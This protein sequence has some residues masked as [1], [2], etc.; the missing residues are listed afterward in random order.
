LGTTTAYEIRVFSMISSRPV[1]VRVSP[2][3]HSRLYGFDI[4]PRKGVVVAPYG[5]KSVVI[6][7]SQVVRNSELE[8]IFGEKEVR[9]RP[10]LIVE[11]VVLNKRE[12]EW[13]RAGTLWDQVGIDSVMLRT[14]YWPGD[15]ESSVTESEMAEWDALDDAA[16][17]RGEGEDGVEKSLAAGPSAVFVMA[18]S[19][20]VERNR[21]VRFVD[22]NA[23]FKRDGSREGNGGGPLEEAMPGMRRSKS[24]IIDYSRDAS[25]V[26]RAKTAT[27][28]ADDELYAV[29]PIAVRADIPQALLIVKGALKSLGFDARNHTAPSSIIA[30]KV[31]AGTAVMRLEITAKVASARVTQI[32]LTKH[33]A[34]SDPADTIEVI[35]AW[36][37]FSARVESA[38]PAKVVAVGELLEEIGAAEPRSKR[39]SAAAPRVTFVDPNMRTGG[40]DIDTT[41][42][43][44]QT[45]ENVEDFVNRAGKSVNFESGLPRGL[46]QSTRG[47]SSLLTT[48]LAEVLGRSSTSGPKMKTPVI[49]ELSDPKAKNFSGEKSKP[50]KEKPK[51]VDLQN[52]PMPNEFPV[53]STTNLTIR[54]H[55]PIDVCRSKAWDV[56]EKSLLCYRMSKTITGNFLVKR[57]GIGQDH[58]ELIE[59]DIIFTRLWT[60]ATLITFEPKS[61]VPPRRA[62]NFARDFAKA[63]RGV[64]K[65]AVMGPDGVGTAGEVEEEKRREVN[66]R[67]DAL[68]DGLVQTEQLVG[69]V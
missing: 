22:Q 61:Y 37:A 7:R 38:H 44:L 3:H 21:S 13:A 25:T 60:D 23:A 55:L 26:A 41:A 10:Q 19:G 36:D 68:A 54:S 65:D 6:A 5:E 1:A 42:E 62:V 11:A 57:G 59:T 27:F 50:A 46:S 63:F 4:E 18:K 49:S 14:L 24:V 53:I 58:F 2:S 64:A 12:R 20:K 31:I 32:E 15:Q 40:L 9:S 17:R 30:E 67:L 43:E 16:A 8:T 34:G 69:G 29:H 51:I 52:I 33:N 28:D 35:D 39:R 48:G 47:K 45:Y 56:L 66:E